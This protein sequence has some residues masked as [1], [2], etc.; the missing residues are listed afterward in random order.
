MYSG[1]IISTTATFGPVQRHIPF[2][3]QPTVIRKR[4]RYNSIFII[5]IYLLVM[6][7]SSF[8]SSASIVI[9]I[10][11]AKRIGLILCAGLAKAIN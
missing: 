7:S 4:T 2:R 8:A 10:L 6:S 9:L 5:S 11:V 1:T 3:G